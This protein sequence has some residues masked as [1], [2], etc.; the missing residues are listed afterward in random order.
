MRYINLRLT[1]AIREC[2]T[3]IYA[4]L[5]YANLFPRPDSGP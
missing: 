5:R 4:T 1:S 3:A 2:L